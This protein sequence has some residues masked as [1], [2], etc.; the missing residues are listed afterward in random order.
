[1]KEKKSMLVNKRGR[2]RWQLLVL[3]VT[4]LLTV[5]ERDRIQKREAKKT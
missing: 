3:R 4:L 2:K 1:V 5:T